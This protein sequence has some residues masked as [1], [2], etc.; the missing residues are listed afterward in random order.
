MRRGRRCLAAKFGHVSVCAGDWWQ[1]FVCELAAPQTSVDLLITVVSALIAAGVAIVILRRQFRHDRELAAD[2]RRAD[3]ELLQV[4]SQLG[5]VAKLGNALIDLGTARRDLNSGQLGSLVWTAKDYAAARSFYVIWTRLESHVTLPDQE[6]VWEL[7]RELSRRWSR[8]HVDA[9]S[10]VVNRSLRL[11]A[12]EPDAQAVG[13][14]ADIVLTDAE[15]RAQAA[16]A[17]LLSWDGVSALDLR[18]AIGG[19]RSHKSNSIEDVKAL[20][21]QSDAFYRI[22]SV[23]VR[24]DGVLPSETRLRLVER[25]GPVP[26]DGSW[27]RI[28]FE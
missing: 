24:D 20:A 7:W 14:A 5:Y 18:A 8:C 6:I 27:E 10:V 23:H 9:R 19:F 11:E 13:L 3:L 15:A 1:R 4:S 25:V 26:A 16:G 2:Q 17:A 12:H 21:A 28:S 22:M